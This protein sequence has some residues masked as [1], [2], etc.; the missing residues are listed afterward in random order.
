MITCPKWQK[1]L[2]DGT[3]FCERIGAKAIPM[4]CGLFDSLDLNSFPYENKVV[5]Q[6]YKEIKL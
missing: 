3:K 2:E 5:P 6:F 4:H 1:Q